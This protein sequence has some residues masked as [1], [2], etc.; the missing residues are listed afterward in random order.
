MLFLSYAREDERTAGSVA[1]ALRV[2]GYRV[3]D[4]RDHERQAGLFI[5][6]IESAIQQADAFIALLSPSFMTSPWCRRERDL[7]M[8]RESDLQL[9]DADA[10]FIYVLRI[11]PGAYADAGFM[12]SYSWVD[13]NPRAEAVAIDVLAGRLEPIGQGEP[14]ENT[15][16][17]D[18][19]LAAPLFRNRREE[20]DKVLRGLTN[21]AGPHFW[22]V[23]APPQLG[24]TWFLDRISAEL[25]E[26]SPGWAARLVDLRDQPAGLRR[27]AKAI[28]AQLFP[29]QQPVAYKSRQ[30]ADI[31]TEI[32]QSGKA[33]LCLID[34]AELLDERTAAGLRASLGE[35][36]RLVQKSGRADVRLAVIVASRREDEWRG[37][38]PPP[39]LVPLP[40]TQFP[41][42]IVQQALGDLADDMHNIFP[43]QQLN[44]WAN[45]VHQLSEGLPEL[46]VGSLQWIRAKEWVQMNHLQSQELFAEL[47]YPYIQYGLLSPDSLVPMNPEPDGKPR[48]ALMQAFRVLVPYRL[49]TRSHLTYHNDRDDALQRAMA[50]AEWSIEDLWKAISGTALLVRPLN[51]PWQEIY[52]A[53]RRLLYRYYYESDES[54]TDAHREARK[55]MEAWA[56]QQYGKEQVIGLVECLWHEAA[57]LRLSRPARIKQE[58]TESAGKLSK[59]LKPSVAYTVEELRSYAAERLQCDEEFQHA[60]SR[61]AGLLGSLARVILTPPEEELRRD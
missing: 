45:Q 35:I 41:P 15:D 11:V 31:A 37:V 2:R 55:F 60:A 5:R 4:W 25:E 14:V 22:L 33:H 53:I 34:S 18:I 23:V 26:Q 38:S 47:A 52:P 21:P 57:Q 54:Q 56:E 3:Y 9:S 40:L 10:V 43:P 24:K 42:N 36:Y 13:L 17:T 46:L 32:L 58:L 19:G 48:Q 20:L 12:R 61:P 29:P 8:Q 27:D 30:P 16:G 59:A 6:E 44:R 1:E 50:D 49:F 51:E 28:L 7:A 39:R